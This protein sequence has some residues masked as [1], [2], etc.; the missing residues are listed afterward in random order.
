MSLIK[1]VMLYYGTV[2]ITMERG[3]GRSFMNIGKY[4]ERAIQSV[5]ILDTKFGYYE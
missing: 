4:L 1:Q 5:D 3:E 2:E